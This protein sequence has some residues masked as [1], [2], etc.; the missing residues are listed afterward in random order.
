MDL[1]GVIAAIDKS[2]AITE[3]EMDGTII[4]ANDNFDSACGRSADVVHRNGGGICKR[5]IE[6]RHEGRQHGRGIGTDDE[7]VMVC[8]KLA[9]DGTGKWELIVRGLVEAHREGPLLLAR[10]L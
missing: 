6:L 3:F 5:L 10:R 8:L 2:Q 1:E 4:T 9:R 7:L